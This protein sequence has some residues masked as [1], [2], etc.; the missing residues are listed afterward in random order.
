MMERQNWIQDKFNFLKMHNR[1]KG[2]CKSS[3]FKSPARGTSACA[4]SA[5]D[6][7]RGSTDTYSLEFRHHIYRT[8]AGNNKNYSKLHPEQGRGKEPSAP[9]IT[10]TDTFL[11]LECNFNICAIDISTARATSVSCKDIH[12]NHPRESYTN[13]PGHPTHSP[14]PSGNQRTPAI[15]RP[16]TPFIIVEN[17]QAGPSRLLTF[18]LIPTKH[19]NPPLVASATDKESQHNISGLSS[20]LLQ[21]VISYLQISAPQPFS[22]PDLHQQTASPPTTTAEQEHQ[23]QPAQPWDPQQSADT[24]QQQQ[25]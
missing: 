18:T 5:H 4:A 23:Q 17:Q 9:A 11:E 6:I 7:S 16:A 3:G 14:E 12:L 20:F 25:Q 13:K 15:Q 19:I 1:H 8:K 10:A 21:S 24:K 2:L 22:P